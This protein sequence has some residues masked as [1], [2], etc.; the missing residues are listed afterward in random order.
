MLK[1]LIDYSGAALLLVFTTFAQADTLELASGALL[2]G[3]FIGSSNGVIMFDAG[4]GIE[5]KH[6]Y[7]S[8]TL[9]LLHDAREVGL[10]VSAAPSLTDPDS[11]SGLFEQARPLAQRVVEF[12]RPPM[13]SRPGRNRIGRGIA[14]AAC[15]DEFRPIRV[16][17][18][19][20]PGA[21]GGPHERPVRR[22]YDRR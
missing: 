14:S 9:T 20:G 3:K 1:R 4:G 13:S 19:E 18:H 15:A 10:T 21:C 6:G 22:R 2:E 17:R 12:A 7:G 5:D 8:T 11:P 16:R